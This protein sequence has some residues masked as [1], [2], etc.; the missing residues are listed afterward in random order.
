MKTCPEC[1]EEVQDAAK[2]CRFCSYRFDSQLSELPQ[3]P[4]CA[5]AIAEERNTCPT[6]GLVLDPQ[7]G[8]VSTGEANAAAATQRAWKADPANAGALARFDSE[9]PEWMRGW[10]GVDRSATTP[11]DV[12]A[13][14]SK[15]SPVAGI[16]AAA[17]VVVALLWF[18]GSLDKPLSGIG[19]NKN[20]CVQNAFGA[21]FCGEDAE[22]LCSEFGGPA[23]ADLGY[24]SEGRLQRELD[25]ELDGLGTP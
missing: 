17:A 1:A 12:I 13:A 19:L 5:Q 2:V 23:C 11:E 14:Q 21:T 15:G 10:K 24:D 16:L 3:C 22:Q 25:E 7:H 18:S 6:C 9:H 4:R 8:N 20:P